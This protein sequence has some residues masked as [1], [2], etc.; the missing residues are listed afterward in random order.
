[1]RNLRPYQAQ[2]REAIRT[3]LNQGNNKLMLVMATGLGK[4]FTGS[5][6]LSDFNKCLWCTHTEELISQSAISILK[7]RIEGLDLSGHTNILHYLNDDDTRG[8]FASDMD[9]MVRKEIGVIKQKREDRHAKITVASVQTLQRRLNKFSPDEYD[10]III[11][12]CHQA[13][14]PTWLKIGEYFKPKLLLGLTATPKRTDNVSL[15][16][17]FDKIAFERDIK[18]GIDEGYLVELNAVRV[19]TH[20]N[21]DGIK[22]TGGDLNQ[23]D[24]EKLLDTPQRNALIVQKFKEY[25]PDRRAIGFCIDTAHARHL[26]TEFNHQG[27]KAEFVVADEEQCPDREDRIM[28]FR[29]GETQVLLN[30]MIMTMGVDIPSVDCIIMARP[31]KSLTLYM[32]A[33]GRGTRTLP[34]VIDH[35]EDAADRVQAIT[36]SSKKDCIVLDIV[37]ATNRHSLINAWSIDKDKNTEDK[38]FITREKKAQIAEKKRQNR[39]LDFDRRTDEKVSLLKV[40]KYE[41]YNTESTRQPATEKQLAWL[42]KLGY[43]IVNT[44]YTKR[45]VSE[46]IGNRPAEEYQLYRLKISGYDVSAGVTFG[47]AQRTIAE[48][49]N[50]ILRKGLKNSSNNQ[51]SGL[52]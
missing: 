42:K 6:I 40:L 52:Q 30:V 24:M 20:I 38:V 48:I 26:C 21:I 33:I 27:I 10:C 7:D 9:R 22:T 32:Q 50:A 12:E 31:T 5:Q 45:D 4:T 34:G 29:K 35:L 41:V 44:A 8:V 17:L 39:K 28:R 19:Q 46:L 15:G 16:N 37:D 11:D 18:F 25:A 14:A 49:D 2:A 51:I 1:M 3:E 47:E 13:V 23:G 36:G 43:D